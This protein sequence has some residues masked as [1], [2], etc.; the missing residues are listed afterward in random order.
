MVHESHGHK[1]GKGHHR[2]HRDPGRGGDD[3]HH[4]HHHGSSHKDHEPRM[5]PIGFHCHKKHRDCNDKYYYYNTKMHDGSLARITWQPCRLDEARDYIKKYKAG[6]DEGETQGAG[7][8]PKSQQEAQS[9]E[10][11]GEK[12]GPSSAQRPATGGAQPVPPQEGHPY[13]GGDTMEPRGPFGQPAP[14]QTGARPAHQWMPE[15]DDMVYDATDP[16]HGPAYAGGFEGM[17]NIPPGEMYE[18]D[19]GAPL[20]E[21][22]G[23]RGDMSYAARPRPTR[24][25]SWPG[26]TIAPA[27]EPPL[28][29]WVPNRPE[30]LYHSDETDGVVKAPPYKTP[31][32]STYDD[33]NRVTYTDY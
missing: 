24:K 4:H 20:P 1:H 22:Y 33:P 8:P 6:P 10:P 18:G 11:R 14:G 21:E 31:S 30:N 5:I 26:S 9:Q 2:H 29:R 25:G 27:A 19:Y 17:P 28:A 13:G 7:H 15:D 32:S 12:A 3:G 23:E 16:Y